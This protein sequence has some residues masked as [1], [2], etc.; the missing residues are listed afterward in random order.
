MQ[1]EVDDLTAQ[2]L[3]L[4]STVSTRDA[5]IGQHLAALDGIANERDGLRNEMQTTIDDLTNEVQEL[6]S[7]VAAKD[8]EFG[9]H[10][11]RLDEIEVDRDNSR[12]EMEKMVEILT[13]EI[14]Q[15]KS[16]AAVK[17]DAIHE[18]NQ[19]IAMLQEDLDKMEIK[20]RDMALACDKA[21]H[22]Q[23]CLETDCKALIASRDELQ[24]ELDM[25]KESLNS[26][27]T[28]RETL[29]QKISSAATAA[30]SEQDIKSS[31]TSEQ[32][33]TISSLQHQNLELTQ[34][35][36]AANASVREAREAAFAAD[37]ELDVKERKLEEILSQL[38]VREEELFAYSQQLDDLKRR[39]EGSDD[40]NETSVLRDTIKVLKE[41]KEQLEV[42]VSRAAAERD[43][44]EQEHR[45]RMGE[46][47]RHLIREAEREMSN[48]RA[49]RDQL[50]S[51][52]AQSET[53]LFTLQ[54]ENERLLEEK[55]RLESKSLESQKSLPLLES[56]V[57]RLKSV[58]FDLSIEK[59]DLASKLK[60]LQRERGSQD[61]KTNEQVVKLAT[62]VNHHKAECYAVRQ[63]S[64]DL[65]ESL[66]MLEQQNQK[67][68]DELQC[69]KQR[70]QEIESKISTLQSESEK[71]RQCIQEKENAVDPDVLHKLQETVNDLKNEIKHRDSRIKKLEVVRL[72]KE[73]CA[74]LKR[75][76]CVPFAFHTFFRIDSHR[77]GIAGGTS[78]VSRGE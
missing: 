14:I 35:L 51:A 69:E 64:L 28:E 56:E 32:S 61:L 77:L 33:E 60:I 72:T 13:S 10:L 17:D 65:Q 18:L 49:V 26:L 78:S 23:F 54:E 37:D 48:L 21:E 73:Q 34:L 1:K 68:L 20:A 24:Q 38:S 47:Q 66:R 27:S 59:K 44:Q 39:L 62:E 57:S 22:E 11:A 40:S 46:E 42:V 7:V 71:L 67:Y 55:K 74:A 43:A 25:T 75:S 76:R 6:R 45:Q 41:E 12:A 5:T 19:N 3:E 30:R 4:G 63:R 52:L 53:A 9:Q 58:N 31:A 16:V 70:R 50:K 29:L 8:E 36:A 15:L 2:V